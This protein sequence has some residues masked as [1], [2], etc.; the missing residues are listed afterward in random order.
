MSFY[1][2][3]G[4]QLFDLILVIPGLLFLLPLFIIITIIIKI[5]LGTPV[6]FNQPRPGKDEKIFTAL[7]FRTMT[8]ERDSSG[9]LLPDSKSITK[10]GGLLR[11]TSMDELP[12]LINVLTGKMSLVGPR[13]LLIEYLDYYSPREKKRHQIRPGI[14]C[15]AQVSGRNILDWYKRLEYDVRQSPT[16]LQAAMVRL[17]AL[18]NF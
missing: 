15:I 12:Q 16:L 6:L 5:N 7:K 17:E 14:T 9:N 1:R 13:P 3:Y 4:K 8:E 18:W 2:N 10:I 11:K